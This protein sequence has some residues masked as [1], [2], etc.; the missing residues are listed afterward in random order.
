MEATML[1][2]PAK[3]RSGKGVLAGKIIS[4]ICVLFLLFDSIMKVIK[5]SHSIEGSAQLGWP[6]DQVQSIGIV[7][8]ISTIL[9]IIPRTAVIG[10]ILLTGYLGGAIAIMVRAGQPLYF[11]AVFAIL[12]WVGLALRDEKVKNL[13]ISKQ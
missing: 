8:L 4:V 6:V 12:I 2:Q 9:Y 13:L 5:E 3:V 11:A 7:L 1:N 10:A